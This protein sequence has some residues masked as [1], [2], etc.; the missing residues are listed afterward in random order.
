MQT[1]KLSDIK[2]VGNF[3]EIL[4]LL[5]DKLIAMESYNGYSSAVANY[6]KL[7]FGELALKEVLSSFNE[8]YTGWN[9]DEQKMCLLYVLI[10]GIRAN[11]IAQKYLNNIE[12]DSVHV[13]LTD[14]IKSDEKLREIFGDV[15]IEE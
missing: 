2:P 1:I 12:M 14:S 3:E 8:P 10:L 9:R 15:I 6:I 13:Q 11:N 4:L 5:N 7:V